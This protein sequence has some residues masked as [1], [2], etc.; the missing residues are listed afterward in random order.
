MLCIGL[1][2]LLVSG[3]QKQIPYEIKSPSEHPAGRDNAA[4]AASAC[5]MIEGETENITTADAVKEISILKSHTAVLH[6]RNLRP[7]AQYQ[8]T[9]WCND[10]LRKEVYRTENPILFVPTDTEYWAWQRFSP[11]FKAHQ[12]GLWKWSAEVKGHGRFSAEF[13]VLPPNPAESSDLIRNEKARENAFRAFANYWLGQDGTFHTIIER[14]PTEEATHH[15]EERKRITAEMGRLKKE[16]ADAESDPTFANS[17]FS[18]FEPKVSRRA[19]K[20]MKDTLYKLNSELVTVKTVNPPLVVANS[21]LG[22]LQIA[23]LAWN[24][25]K[26][27]ITEAD[28]LNGVTYRGSISFRFRLFRFCKPEGWTD[29]TDSLRFPSSLVWALG[30]IRIPSALVLQGK[31]NLHFEVLERDDNWFVTTSMGNEFA[32]GKLVK[33]G[34]EWVNRAPSPKLAQELLTTRNNFKRDYFKGLGNASRTN[35]QAMEQN[36]IATMNMLRGKSLTDF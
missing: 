30:S 2:I 33:A 16:I 35:P 28:T 13:G 5:F 20:E 8:L 25:S 3:C 21:P 32:N 1:L 22:Y 23:G 12:A 15:E 11:N 29:W 10:G 6:L 19:V 4:S 36:V 27:I 34:E 18:T 31:L 17:N 26:H 14:Y 9:F 24:A 7:G